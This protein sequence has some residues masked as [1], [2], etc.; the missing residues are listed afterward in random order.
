MD[1]AATA[2][3]RLAEADSAFARADWEAARALYAAAL[4]AEPSAEALD[5]L[6]WA[7]WWLGQNEPAFEFLTRAFSEYRRRGDRERADYIVVFVA[8]EFRIA[9]N[10]SV[11]Q[12]WLGRTRRLLD[13]LPECSSHAWFE[14]ELSKRAED[15]QDEERH[16]R[17]ALEIARRLDDPSLEVTALSHVGLALITRGAVDVGLAYLDESMAAATGGEA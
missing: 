14:I 1:A 3:R 13:G 7:L 8:A 10:A 6:G 11:G 12:G 5:G 16:A 4:E 15:P 9:G 17:S 2:S